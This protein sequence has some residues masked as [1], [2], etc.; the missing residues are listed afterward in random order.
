MAADLPTTD[1]PNA[2]L[3]QKPTGVPIFVFRAPLPTADLR[4]QLTC[5]TLT[6]LASLAHAA[7]GRKS[8]FTQGRLKDPGRPLLNS[9]RLVD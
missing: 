9:G 2:A 5:P 4:K 1:V 7:F 8:F 3:P 6:E